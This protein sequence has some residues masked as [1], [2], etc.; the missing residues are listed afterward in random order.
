MVYASWDIA[1]LSIAESFLQRQPRLAVVAS[2]VGSMIHDLQQNLAHYNSALT[3]LPAHG[4]P[5]ATLTCLVM[6]LQDLAGDTLR[7]L[8]WLPAVFAAET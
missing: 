1:L 6:G 2:Q 4:F 3:A 5:A 7:L 8:Q